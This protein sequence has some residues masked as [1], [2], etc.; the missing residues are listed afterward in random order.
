VKKVFG[1]VIALALV[2]T[3]AVASAV[4][5]AAV[6]A[7]ITVCLSNPIAGENSTY[8]IFF[9]NNS[10]LKGAD[11]DFI[12]LM[13]PMGTVCTGATVVSVEKSAAPYTWPASCG[14]CACPVDYAANVAPA[15]VTPLSGYYQVASA[16]SIRV[17]LNVTGE[18]IDKCEFVMI[19]VAN[20]TNP[21]S[22]SHHLEVGTS[23]HT[24]VDSEDYTIYCARLVLAG[25]KDP[26]TGLDK[27][28]L[29][30]LPCY[31]IDTSIEV[32]LADLFCLKAATAGTSTPF[33]FSVWY[34]DNV[35][36][37]WVKYVSDTSFDDLE[38]IEAGKAYWIKP[39]TNAVV[40]IHGSPYP[41]GQG[42]PV[43]W[44]YPFCWNMVGFASLTAM[45]ASQYL[46]YTQIP[47]Y[48]HAVLAIWSFDSGN[49]I[50]HDEGWDT[51][52]EMTPG[53]GYWMAF[54]AEACIIPP[55]PS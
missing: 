26:L 4:P 54:I 35:N 53:Q 17:T 41:P 43:K 22:C 34:Y 27:M 32:V 10:L 6:S 25:G 36:K 37:A 2:L 23:T 46:H 55:A 48:G 30:S 20:V 8:C 33:S 3:M 12:D 40:Y 31:P 39:S 18:I 15:P 42:P 11:L 1:I 14:P 38:T 44:C 24:P 49:Q 9:H 13:F 50:Y 45:N 19:T 47:F 29:I 5:A 7:P 28:N 16:K 21:W 52:F 51:D